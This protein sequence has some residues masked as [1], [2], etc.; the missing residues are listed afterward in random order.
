[1]ICKDIITNILLKGLH[2]FGVEAGDPKEFVAAVK[3]WLGGTFR[4]GLVPALWL[5]IPEVCMRFGLTLYW[6]QAMWIILR[7][8]MKG[9]D[10]GNPFWDWPQN[11][12]FVFVFVIGYAVAAAEKHGLRD[13]LQKGRWIYF[14]TGFLLSAI[15]PWTFFMLKGPM[16]NSPYPWTYHI[17]NGTLRWFFYLKQTWK[18]SYLI[19]YRAFGEWLMVLGI[20]S[21]AR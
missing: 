21:M 13:F 3:W 10:F 1:M 6:H 15:K 5:L 11:F 19:L 8:W 20:Y 14:P 16:T 9:Q 2:F 7:P 18:S 12:N 4:L 17:L